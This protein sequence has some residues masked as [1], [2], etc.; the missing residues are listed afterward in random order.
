MNS[1]SWRDVSERLRLFA[2]GHYQIQRFAVGEIGDL[3][4]EQVDATYPLMFAVHPN[5]TPVDGALNY[6]LEILF[7][8]L[9][10]D[11]DGKGTNQV[12]VIS[13]LARIALDLISE[14][15][16]GSDLFGE[17]VA[18]VGGQAQID[19]GAQEYNNNLCVARLTFSLEIPFA[20][21]ACE[22]PA[23]YAPAGS[24]QL[25]GGGYP[26]WCDK[27]IY[28]PVIIQ[29][30]ADLDQKLEFVS[31]DGVTII[32]DGTPGNPLEAVGGGG[33][34][35]GTVTSVAL[36]VPSAFSVTGSPVT[37]SGTLAV[38]GAGT[39][40]Q[41]I[42]GTGALQTFPTLPTGTV[43]SVTDLSPSAIDNTDPA[44]PVTNIIPRSGTDS[45]FPVTGDIELEDSVNTSTKKI[46]STDAVNYETQVLFD[47]EGGVRLQSDILTSGAQGII[48]T[49][50]GSFLIQMF[51]GT[52][53]AAI[54]C[55]TT[56][57]SIRI[58]S[59][60]PTFEGLVYQADYSAN[61]GLL[62]VI[63]L[64]TFKKR[65]WTK[66]GTPTTTDDDSQGFIVGS[67]IW[68]TTN[69]ILYRAT[70]VTPS[71]A[72]WTVAIAG[73]GSGTVN[74][75]TANRLTYYAATGT[76]VSELSAI[77]ALRALKSDANGLP[78]A[79]DT[80]TEP[81][82]TELSYVKGVTS[83]IQ[84]Q[85]NA[86]VDTCVVGTGLGNTTTA[87]GVTNFASLYAGQLTFSTTEAARESLAP[88][89]LSVSR[90]FLRTYN[91]QPGT[92][93]YV[94]TLRKNG[95]NESVTFTIAAGS[96]A[97][98]FSD[99]TNSASYSAGDRMCVKFVNNA[100]SASA[101]SLTICAVLTKS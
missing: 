44:N 87:A 89:D 37:T 47:E 84:T 81:S 24:G 31:V 19:T 69:S 99:I 49:T 76:T 9:A 6:S 61:Y 85:L 90:L 71:A 68:D 96:A 32:G 18:V 91:A 35:S 46:Y 82:L 7:V 65:F 93:S 57:N 60:L 38:T 28:C 59:D 14:V 53:S 22:I 63:D 11:F 16:N 5:I 50:L 88:Y 36:T 83:A 55:F 12:Q 54:Q 15:K 100:S 23:E 26:D 20:W 40:G 3:D 17:D 101:Q 39:S 92:G 64:T 94:I 62:S 42:D 43:E 51:D 98:N 48:K 27:L 1:N 97:G 30:L 74:S 95:A 75:G 34:G 4:K 56:D 79:F 77:T 86:K 13:D 66:A 67:L 2:E 8:D 73:G 80:A 78:V 70:D 10:R 58:I 52:N 72:T 25:P 41:Y 29:I 33:G 21:N 45:G